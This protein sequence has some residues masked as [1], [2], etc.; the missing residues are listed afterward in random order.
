M[1]EWKN[2]KKAAIQE[3]RPY[4]PGEDL[5]GISVSERDTP[6]VGG[7][8]ARGA[9]DGALWYVSKTFFNENYIQADE[10]CCAAAEFVEHIKSHLGSGE[11]VVCKV[12]NR[13]MLDITRQ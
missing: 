4:I 6:E 3:M 1:S 2:Y 11:E 7:M 12:C 9:D 10:F 13:T 5:T 8:I